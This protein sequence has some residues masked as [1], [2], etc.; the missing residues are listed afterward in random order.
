MSLYMIQFASAPLENRAES[1]V[2]KDDAELFTGVDRGWGVI[3]LCGG[4][5]SAL[6][7]GRGYLPWQEWQDRLCRGRRDLHE[8]ARGGGY[9]Q[10]QIGRGACRE[11]GE[12]SG[13]GGS[14]KK[15]KSS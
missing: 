7:E 14:L 5:V 8:Q 1:H 11:R 3:G 6:R 9:G 12:I 2:K 4:A 13:G 10:S 15:K